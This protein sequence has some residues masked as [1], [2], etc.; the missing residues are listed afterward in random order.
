MSKKDDIQRAA[1]RIFYRRGFHGVGIDTV[2]EE[3]GVSPRT[4]YKHFASKDDLAAAVLRTRGRRYVELLQ[5]CAAK[6]ES[7]DVAPL[8]RALKR[9]L[10]ADAARGCMF[11][12]ALAEYKAR[13]PGIEAVVRDHKAEVRGI[14]NRYLRVALGRNPGPLTD[15]VL[16]LIEGATAQSTIFDTETVVARARRAAQRLVDASRRGKKP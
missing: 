10:A 15:D 3:A 13:H 11:F 12:N 4:L 14:V 2:I 7:G 9:W 6:E 16:L 8:F 1:E 5:G